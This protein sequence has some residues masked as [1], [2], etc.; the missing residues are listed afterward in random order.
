MIGKHNGALSCHEVIVLRFGRSSV[1]KLRNKCLKLSFKIVLGGVAADATFVEQKSF[2]FD[3]IYQNNDVTSRHKVLVQRFR[4]LFVQKL[5]KKYLKLSFRI[6][7]G[8]VSAVAVATPVELK[9]SDFAKIHEFDQIPDHVF[10]CWLEYELRSR[11]NTLSYSFN[12]ANDEHQITKSCLRHVAGS[13]ERTLRG[14]TDRTGL[15]GRAKI[16]KLTCQVIKAVGGSYKSEKKANEYKTSPLSLSCS[17]FHPNSSRHYCRSV[18]DASRLLRCGDIETNPGPNPGNGDRLVELQVTTHNVRGLG[19]SRKVRHLINKCYKMCNNGADN[20]FMFQETYVTRL[21][22]LSY[23]WRGEFFLTPGTGNSLGCLTLV[24]SP[25]KIMR[26]IDIGNRGHILIITKDDI[27]KV[28]MIIAN[29]YAPN[30][31]GEA[32][33]E[34]FRTIIDDL[35]E[36]QATYGCDKVIFA[37][38][39]NLVF[40]ELEVKNRIYSE[41]EKRTSTHVKEIFNEAGLIDGWEKANQRQFTWTSN[42][43]GQPAFS[44]LDRI[45]FNEGHLSLIDKVSDWSFSLSDHAAVTA[46]F[47]K[48]IVINKQGLISRLD[49]RILH[50]E[51]GR[52]LLNEAFQELFEQRSQQWNPHVSLEFAKMCIRTAAASSS[53]VLKA[54][55]R[56][57][58]VTLNSDINDVI[59]ELAGELCE[60]RKQL[61]IAKLDDLR[62]LKRALVERLGKKLEI[63][64]ARRW[65]NEGELSSK[66]FFNLLNRKAN[67]EIKVLVKENGDEINEQACIEEEIRT[68]Y[69]NLYELVPQEIENNDD[70]FRNVTPLPQDMTAGIGD[71]LTVDE[72]ESTLKTCSDSSPGPD[73]IPYSFLRFFWKDYGPVLLKA[74]DYSL[75]INELPPSHKQSYLKLIP[76]AGKDARVIANLRPITL[77]NTDHKLISKTYAKKLTSLLTSQICEEQTA[78]IPGR[79]I[80]DNVRSILMSIDLAN[81]DDQV[82]GVVVSLDAKKAFDSVDH[83]FIRLCLRKFGL[84]RFVPIFDTLYKDLKSDILLNGSL[85]TGY[86]ILKG[87]KQGDA[88]SCILF[89]MCIEPLMRNIKE[90]NMISRITSPRLNITVP[91]VLGFADDVSVITKRDE[92][93]IKE[94]FQEYESFSKSSGLVLNANKTEILC[95]NS[96]QQGLQMDVEYMGT[97]HRLSSVDRIKINGIWMLQDPREREDLNVESRINSTVKLLEAWSRRRLT[98]LGRILIIKTYAVSQFVYLLQSMSINEV[99]KK[100]ITALFF[101]YLWN[102][103]LRGNRAPE[104]LKREIMLTPAK[105]GGFGMVDFNSLNEALDLRSYGRM[106]TSSHPLF[107]QLRQLVNYDDFFNVTIE[108]AVDKKFTNSLG[109][110]NLHRKEI[111][112]WHHD[113]ISS[114]LRLRSLL[115]DMKLATCLTNAGRQSIAFFAIHIRV[116]HPRLSQLTAREFA[117]IARFFKDRNLRAITEA[118]IG[119]PHPLN[120]EIDRTEAYP[121]QGNRIVKVSTLSS[122]DLR[123]SAITLEE[124]II[125]VY[126][127]GLILTP[128][129]VLSW[130]SK[131]KKLTST[132]HK[133]IALRV[134]HG[135]IFS[136]SRLFKFGL[137]ATPAC[138]NC[139]EPIETVQHRLY[140]CPMAQEAWL[141]LDEAMLKL[142]LTPLSNYTLENVLG[143]GLRRNK[144]ELALQLEL[145]LRLSTKSEQYN[146]DQLAKSTLTF[147][148]NAEHLNEA[149]KEEFSRYKRGH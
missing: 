94:I 72:L 130:T 6:V 35:I 103:N 129:E 3:K 10:G 87:V 118:L 135:D 128:G 124:S 93:C 12:Y 108:A 54:R 133:N 137:R 21:E 105:L 86:K 76:K 61:L 100:R 40:N 57:D 7:L 51:E 46:T 67:D 88:L 37:G 122:K 79:L 66:Y 96:D 120:T 30:I 16:A 85:V 25:L 1:Q 90:S 9:S 117:T 126:K 71:Q 33:V 56:D 53:G 149:T 91:K 147:V 107:V 73:G 5:R 47:K 89:I 112:R 81:F 144:L 36:A 22:L 104:R 134:A 83:R 52:R 27:N 32:K 98:L 49:P 80:N 11:Y 58:E 55:Y 34:F 77:S 121:Y 148:C 102:K 119:G 136:N 59:T 142:K 145:L 125:C 63:R 99:N 44:T 97:R 114:N 41:A 109:L 138:S 70:L 106:L 28:E 65:Y 78:Y 75:A 132:R 92:R 84:D 26:T 110:L 24:T 13:T 111:L 64:A 60:A 15:T 4:R 127:T 43:S 48:K 62:H 50:D 69:K 29:A 82:D 113:A 115:M 8:G 23:L 131:I 38:D 2:E 146:A 140:E 95:F 19:D 139:Q 68:F 141:K 123:E 45:L 31:L 20:V 116:N 17:S 143:A 18:L 39:L 14:R 74:W 42:R 101:K